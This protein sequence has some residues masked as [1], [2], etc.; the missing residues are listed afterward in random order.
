MVNKSA[1]WIIG[2]CVVA[3][4]GVGVGVAMYG[5][6]IKTNRKVFFEVTSATVGGAGV[7]I[8]F[9]KGDAYRVVGEVTAVDSAGNA[10]VDW[11]E[12]IIT[13]ASTK[14]ETKFKVDDQKTADDSDFFGT[15]PAKLVDVPVNPIPLTKLKKWWFF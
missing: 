12:L 8:T 15:A 3:L 13:D 1:L 4:G 5:R 10:T 11:S 6:K 9:N 2:G 14:K 7:K